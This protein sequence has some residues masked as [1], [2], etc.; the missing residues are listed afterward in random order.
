MNLRIPGPTPCPDNVLQAMSRQMVNHRGTVFTDLLGRLTERMKQLFQTKNDLFF[1]SCSGTGVL[2][3]MVVNTLSPGDKVLC[4]SIGAFG[5][6]FAQIA[7]TYGAKLDTIEFE[8]G[9][10]A[11]PEKVAE[12]VGKDSYKAVMVTHNETSTGVTNDLGA[13][14]K[15]VRGV[16]PDILMLV[17]AVSSLGSIPCP[18]DEWD[19]DMVGT[20]SQKAWMVPPGLTMISVSARAWKA[21][22]ES[23]MPRFYLDVGK[24][25][26]FL[27]RPT[28]QTPWTPTVSIF[29]ALDVALEQLVKEGV[30]GIAKRHQK[31]GD[32]ARNGVKSLGLELFADEKHASNTV[33]AV[34]APD[35][36]DAN[37]L[38]K[39]VREEYDTELAGGQGKL[40]GKVFRIGHLGYCSV[41]DIDATIDALRKALPK[42][43]YKLP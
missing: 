7:E 26:S 4:V 27:E 8:W 13:I 2:E 10:A 17:D 23:K 41:E 15:A 19:L 37:D 5:N 32:A 16:A 1:L 39:I 21:Y 28:P 9:T 3:A 30:D 36:M 12:A 31:L 20:G 38:R 40:A 34:K 25:K 18:V 42:L 43:G 6:R 35:G 14:S 24:A 22:E 33:T 29:Y 11:D